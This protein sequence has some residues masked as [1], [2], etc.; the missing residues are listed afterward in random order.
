MYEIGILT[1]QRTSNFGSMLQAFALCKA[2]R[3]LG[4]DCDIVDYTCVAVEDREALHPN[5]RHLEL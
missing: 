2:V 1:F 3:N 4:Y 5:L